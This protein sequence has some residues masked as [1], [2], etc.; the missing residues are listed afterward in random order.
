M[1]I[2]RN[3]ITLGHKLPATQVDRFLKGEIALVPR[4][5]NLKGR[6]GWDSKLS[7]LPGL[8]E[9]MQMAVC[10]QPSNLQQQA[11]FPCCLSCPECNG[12]VLSSNTAFQL[13]DLDKTC[14]CNQ[15]KRSSKVRDWRCRCG[16]RWHQCDLHSTFSNSKQGIDSPR[17]KPCRGIKR[18]YGPFTHEELVD[19]DTKRAR[20]RPPNILPP[21]QLNLSVKLRERFPHLFR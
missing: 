8:K 16:L 17:D 1:H 20:R 9:T 15:C 2:R 11:S 12:N 7:G 4:L 3:L 6:T 19:I 5:P 10:K 14:K 21:A 18:S 13:R